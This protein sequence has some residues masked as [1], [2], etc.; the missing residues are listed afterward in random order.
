MPKMKFSRKGLNK[1]DFLAIVA[2]RANFSLGDVYLVWNAIEEV[3]KD[4]IISRTQ[5]CIQSFGKL[6]F[7]SIAKKRTIDIYGNYRDHPPTMSIRFKFASTM[8]N[9]IKPI[10]KRTFANKAT[11]DRKIKEYYENEKLENGGGEENG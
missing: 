10:E 7:Y 5:I 8:R 9:L 11:K 3:F 6:F 1:H 2:Q 4:A